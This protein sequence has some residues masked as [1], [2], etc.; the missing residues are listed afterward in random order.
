MN[1]FRKW[2]LATLITWASTVLALLVVLQGSHTLHGTAAR[3]VDLAAGVLQVLL[4]AYAHQHV[5][6]VDNPRARDGRRLVPLRHPQAEAP[7]PAVVQELTSQQFRMCYD[8]QPHKPH[9][10]TDGDTTYLCAGRQ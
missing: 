6:P 9:V 8:S 1:P 7:S 2:P 10:W 3:W 4:T 5:T